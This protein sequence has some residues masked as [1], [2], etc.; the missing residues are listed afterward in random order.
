MEDL[1]SLPGAALVETHLSVVVFV[2]DRAYKL[3]KP[4]QF[5][6]IDLRTRVARERICHREVELNRRLAPDVY[7]GVADVLGPDGE[8]CDHLVV[9]RRMPTGARLST[10]VADGDPAVPGAL[11]DLARVLAGFHRAADRSAAIDGAGERDTLI[12]LWRANA[13]E[14]HR[15]DGTVFPAG[16]SGDA[17]RLAET[18]LLGRDALLARRRSEAC[19]CDGHGDLM[20]DDVFVLPDGPR[21]LD[22]IEF[23]DGLRYGDVAADIAFLAMDLERLGARDLAD[24]FVR[25]YE[26]AANAPVPR[27]LLHLYIAYRAQ[28]RAKVTALR[29]E[30]EQAA[31][32]DDAADVDLARRLLDLCHRHLEA[33]T[34][35]LVLVGGSPGTGKSTVARGIGERLGATVLRSDVVRKQRAG[36]SETT[37]AA[38][39]FGD[40]IYTNAATDETYDALVERAAEL[41]ALGESVVLD[42]SFSSA[43]HR[44]VARR[45]ADRCHATLTELCCVLDPAEAARRISRRAAAGG[46]ASDAG[47][48]VA[49]QLAAHADPWPEAMELPT[50][51]PVRN[52]TNRAVAVVSVRADHEDGHGG[53]EDDP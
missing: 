25:A 34:V 24:R 22:C 35:R 18:Y 48:E 15:F 13:A 4:V 52:V 45:L 5:S 23:D 14:M 42:A 6:F 9:M 20:A 17:L 2:G 47:P 10:L 29:A 31:G 12:G 7:E 21:V 28:V 49:A 36:L 37:S 53:V 40:G 8:V 43:R 51:G 30:Q 26:K 11:V 38:A 32:G 41:L 16:S 19:I 1:T 3:K 39:S 50:D 46:D 33:A 27:S 44:D